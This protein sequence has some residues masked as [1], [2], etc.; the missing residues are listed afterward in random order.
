[1]APP[2][3]GEPRWDA[4]AQRWVRDAPAAPPAPAPPPPPP[5]HAPPA[6]APAPAP[7][8][9]PAYDPH[10][11][12]VPA[13]PPRPAGPRARWLTPATAGIAVA[14]AVV[15]AGAV[16]YVRG[17][18]DDPAR[19]DGKHATAVSRTPATPDGT[20]AAPSPSTSRSPSPGP[21]G[22]GGHRT[23]QDP[24]GFTVAVP[25]GWVR[26]EGTGGVFYRSPDRTALLQIFQ[27]KEADLTPLEA[28]KGASTY[29]RAQTPAY[30]EIGV[31]G[32]P[33][34][35]V[36]AELVYEYDSA[37]SHGRRRGVE[38]VFL[39]SGGSGSAGGGAKWAVLTAGPADE[40]TVTREHHEA[41][42][43]AFRAP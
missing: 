30:E 34:D 29:L 31:G 36:A 17:G 7:A 5:L 32:V 28:V 24:K 12:P 6:P 18:S 38:R 22:T 15:A 27:V 40:W 3:S 23:V 9:P 21:S 35:P 41:A 4:Q 19:A 42:L 10:R 37:E 13:G 25:K 14:A 11:P 16:W 33:G 1:M 26:E 20:S 8:P 39:P 43:A 2:P